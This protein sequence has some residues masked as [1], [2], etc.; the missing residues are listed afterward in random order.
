M[1]GDGT[2]GTQDVVVADG[3]GGDS[4]ALDT[5][6]MDATPLDSCACS[7]AID[8][9]DGELCTI[10]LCNPSDATCS[11]KPHTGACDNGDLCSL[12]D[13]CGVDGKCVRDLPVCARHDVLVKDKVLGGHVATSNGMT[14]LAGVANVAA[15][16]RW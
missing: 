16:E 11:H 12:T 7:A 6:P 4:E 14:A 3:D 8:C 15:H 2:S 10:D 5:T 1:L 9:D 13:T